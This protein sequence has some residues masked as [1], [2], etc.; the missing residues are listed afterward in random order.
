MAFLMCPPARLYCRPRRA[1]SMGGSIGS[2]LRPTMPSQ[3]SARAGAAQ[4]PYVEHPRA[5]PP[6]VDDLADLRPDLVGDD[7]VGEPRGGVLEIELRLGRL[8]HV[9]VNTTTCQWW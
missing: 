3:M 9:V 4:L 2:S 1:Q 5:H 8:A 7:Q 6:G